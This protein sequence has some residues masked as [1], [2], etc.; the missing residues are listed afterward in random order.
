MGPADPLEERLAAVERRLEAIER[1]LTERPT[2]PPPAS[3][4]PAIE[5][6]ATEIDTASI[7]STVGLIGRTLIVLGG[8]F[9]I[10]FLTESKMLPHLGGTVGGI[11]YA[12]GWVF[13][14]DRASRRGDAQSAT[15]HGLAAALIG[16]PLLW[17]TTLKFEYLAPLQSAAAVTI[18]TAIPL[19]VARSR[20]MRSLAAVIGAPAAVTMLAL[21]FATKT[22]PPFFAAL[23]VLGLASLVLA[24]EQ[25][26]YGLGA[27]VALVAD[28]G[29]TLATVIRLLRPDGEALTSLGLLSLSALQVALGAVY[30]GT[31]SAL[32]FVRNRNLSVPEIAQVVVVLL[33]GFGGFFG[34][35][36]VAPS[37]RPEL[38]IASFALSA[39]CYF[40]A[41]RLLRR[42]TERQRT[43]GVYSATAATAGLVGAYLCFRGPV[44]SVV[45]ALAALASSVFGSRE[46]SVTLG[47]HGAAYI[48]AAALAS[49]LAEGLALIYAGTTLV[50]A[51]W[52]APAPW[53]VIAVSAAVILLQPRSPDGLFERNFRRARVPALL[54][55]AAT[56][57]ALIISGVFFLYPGSGGG[58]ERAE[59]AIL[60]TAVLSAGAVLLA[61]LGRVKRFAQSRWLVSLFL[62]AGGAKLLAEDIPSGEPSILFA[63]LALYG[64]ALILAPRLLKKPT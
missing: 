3:G 52:W 15:F 39:A 19:A 40:G 56:L 18:F 24:Y 10:R 5:P 9:L 42:E 31:F 63:C 16:F 58:F 32:V 46:R 44:L 30:F 34:A 61:L 53:T 17:E 21:A 13:M 28:F 36:H 49:G 62:A 8:A 22:I 48:L 57:G 60:R 4:R 25:K 23:L 54:L 7:V 27:F 33:I 14:A 20:H 47:L 12:L 43:F 64:A 11:V 37:V 6:A 45:L 50:P 29:V 1:R 55:A 2:A 26:W 35:A 51:F 59:S 41:Y 38:G